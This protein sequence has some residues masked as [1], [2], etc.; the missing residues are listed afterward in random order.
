MTKHM[1]ADNYINVKQNFKEY[2]DKISKEQETLLVIRKDDQD[3]V[4]LS[5]ETYQELERAKNNMDYLEKLNKSIEQR[6]QGKVTQ[7]TLFDHDN[8]EE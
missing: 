5:I 4:I 3:I 1:L 2:C 7:V 6:K 8:E